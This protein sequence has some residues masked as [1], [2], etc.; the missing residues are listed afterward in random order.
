MSNLERAARQALKRLETAQVDADAPGQ[1]RDI[2]EIQIAGDLWPETAALRAAL[3]QQQ[4]EPVVVDA[5]AARE[6]QQRARLNL[7][8]AGRKKGPS[9]DTEFGA[10]HLAED[11][12]EAQQAEPAVDKLTTSQPKVY[13][14]QAEPVAWVGLTDA[15]IYECW[16]GVESMF[17]IARAIEA[18]LKEKNAKPVQAE[19]VAD[20]SGNASY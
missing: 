10:P 6:S 15:E 2:S 7:R 11:A 4:A 14:E 8:L 5:K 9:A 18:A 1:C 16:P 3:A 13:K 19:P 20:D 12:D 17:K